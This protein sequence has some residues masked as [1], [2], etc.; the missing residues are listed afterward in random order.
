M[1]A[2]KKILAVLLLI[3]TALA[4]TSCDAFHKHSWEKYLTKVPTC[5]EKGILKELCTDCGE[6][7]LSEINTMEHSYINGLCVICG[8]VQSSKRELSPVAIP[9]GS[10]NSGM[11]SLE[12]VYD[13]AR[14]FVKFNSYEQFIGSLT[15]ASIKNARLGMFNSFNA[16]AVV[17]LFDN[18]IGEFPVLLTYNTVS[19]KSSGASLGVLLRADIENGELLLT[20]TTGQQLSAGY[21][22]S[23]YGVKIVG[24]GINA[25]NEFIIY[26]S[27]ETIAFAGKIAK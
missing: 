16:T 1:K 3:S 5:T 17:T 8:N 12:K 24:F 22:N 9:Y 14:T 25:D 19:P 2:L 18:S 4:I 26:Y 7:L 20:Y 6:V 13:L 23:S 11:W 21:M 15:G 10:D 27:N